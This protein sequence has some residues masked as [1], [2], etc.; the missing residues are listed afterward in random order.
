MVSLILIALGAVLSFSMQRSEQRNTLQAMQAW[1]SAH[2]YW[3]NRDPS[4]TPPSPYWRWRAPIRQGRLQELGRATPFEFIQMGAGQEVWAMN[5]VAQLPVHEVP[6]DVVPLVSLS[7]ASFLGLKLSD[8]PELFE[9]HA[10]QIVGSLKIWRQRLQDACGP[11]APPEAAFPRAVSHRV[12]G[13]E[14]LA[15]RGATGVSIAVE[16]QRRTALPLADEASPM[17]DMVKRIRDGGQPTD[18]EWRT[19]GLAGMAALELSLL[20]DPSLAAAFLELARTGPSR[21]DRIAGLWAAKQVG[22]TDVM[23]SSIE[24]GKL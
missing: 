7:T 18:D 4:E 22:A 14:G 12:A 3:S 17:V 11:C 15:E 5:E 9:Q 10:T 24:S 21:T 23:L 20:G 13:S 6:V 1:A 19:P 8:D 16:Q 2:A